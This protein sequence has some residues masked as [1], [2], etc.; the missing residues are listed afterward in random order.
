[1]AHDRCHCDNFHHLYAGAVLP[2]FEGEMGNGL[3]L[4]NEKESS[5]GYS[6]HGLA[7]QP[8]GALFGGYLRA[9]GL[10]KAGLVCTVHN[11]SL[12]MIFGCLPCRVSNVH[13]GIQ[14]RPTVRPLH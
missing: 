8:I 9:A 12:K 2:D 13:G 4:S 10:C 14:I 3:M 1:M 11:I 5:V 7:F 6:N